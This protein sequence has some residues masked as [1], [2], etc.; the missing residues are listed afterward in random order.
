VTT[1]AERCIRDLPAWGSV[2]E[3]TA[4]L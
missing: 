2:F 1:T 3:A 4:G